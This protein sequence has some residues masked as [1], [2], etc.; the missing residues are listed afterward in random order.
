M[1]YLIEPKL[2]DSLYNLIS[3]YRQNPLKS[4]NFNQI[5]NEPVPQPESHR[6]KEWALRLF[7]DEY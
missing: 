3:Y 4:Y 7:L 5:L 2:F 1:Y 6:D